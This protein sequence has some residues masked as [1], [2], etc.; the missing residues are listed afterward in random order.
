MVKVSV[1]I[2]IFN[3]SRYIADCIKRIQRQTLKEI[4]I[5]CVDD[6]SKDDSLY[7]LRHMEKNDRRIHIFEQE[8]Q[9]AGKARNLAIRNAVGEF[10]CFLDVDDYFVADNALKELYST[11]AT[12]N[13]F[14]CGGQFYTTFENRVNK[15]SVYGSLWDEKQNGKILEYMDYQQ[16]FY[17]S[18]YLYN[19]QMLQEN[20]ITFPD[21][22]Q[23]EDPPFC[24]KALF[25]A[26]KIYVTNIPFY[27]YRIGYK[28]RVYSEKI[29]CDQINA[30]M[31]NLRFSRQNGLKKLHCITY[32]R[33]VNSCRRELRRFYQNQNGKLRD[34]LREVEQT[35]CWEWLEEKCR[36]P[37]RKF[38]LFC[39]ISENEKSDEDWAFP[40]GGLEL[41][42]KV[43]LYGAGEVGRSY[44]RQL[45]RNGDMLLCAWVDENARQIGEID[46]TRIVLPE[47]LSA[48]S[49]DY[50][51]IAIANMMVALEIMD[52]LSMIGVTPEK[53][54]WNI[55]R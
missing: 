10:V 33:M 16:D 41:G 46:G 42:K 47:C 24:A 30:M 34:L 3:G 20:N 1:I 8:N 39:D 22:R 27:C 32:Y 18:N 31:D 5:L 55:G 9:G 26:G 36:V 19:R 14:V 12:Q 25:A 35:V 50:I 11:A 53:V 44:H 43:V 17:F 21:Y 37:E 2:P 7:I 40:Y 51:V 48:I 28:E 15:V 29:A 4:E 52:T 38:R 49:F 6:G 54:I 13:V 23:F 45:R